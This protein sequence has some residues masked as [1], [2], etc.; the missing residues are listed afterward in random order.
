ML[1]SL[2]LRQRE[3]RWSDRDRIESR[4]RKQEQETADRE[5][6]LQ[7]ELAHSAT[8]LD[9]CNAEYN[10]QLSH[11]ELLR[12][13]ESSVEVAASQGLLRERAELQHERAELKEVRL[14]MQE[15]QAELKQQHI[16]FEEVRSQLH[17]GQKVAAD[18]QQRDH[19]LHLHHQNEALE[20]QLEDLRRQLKLEQNRRAA[21]G[22]TH[23]DDQQCIVKLQALID[24]QRRDLCNKIREAED[25]RR[26]LERKSYAMRPSSLRGVG[27]ATNFGPSKVEAVNGNEHVSSQCANNTPLSKGGIPPLPQN[28]RSTRRVQSEESLRVIRSAKSSPTKLRQHRPASA[29]SLL[30]PRL[31]ASTYDLPPSMPLPP[32][33]NS[34]GGAQPRSR[35]V[36][37]RN[38]VN[39][40]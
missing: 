10:E 24:S 21:F 8:L 13:A 26:K 19:A 23:E 32:S 38:I 6:A 15:E 33:C 40:E 30:E 1:W 27:P 12:D 31:G 4:Q 7:T 2:P 9:L 17:G 22:K 20:S 3:M 16:A 14:Q 25:L 39:L 11:M 36:G 5:E 34:S 29:K 18:R 37:D 28:D 35:S